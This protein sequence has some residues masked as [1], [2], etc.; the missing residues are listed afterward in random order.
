MGGLSRFVFACARARACLLVDL[1]RLA[2]ITATFALFLFRREKKRWGGRSAPSF[3]T[4]C[5]DRWSPLT[6]SVLGSTD[7]ADAE[8]DSLRGRIYA[9]WQSLG[10]SAVPNVGDNGVH[11]SASPFEACAERCNWL[12][13]VLPLCMVDVRVEQSVI[14]SSSSRSYESAGVWFYS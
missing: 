2:P 14:W 13:Y 9:S 5:P 3:E 11:A 10:L 4:R 6:A 1:A 12:S 8:A 7:P